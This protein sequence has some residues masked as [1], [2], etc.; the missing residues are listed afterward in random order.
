MK[1]QE[2]CSTEK[3]VFTKDEV[4][5]MFAALLF[6]EDQWHVAE[7]MLPF[8]KQMGIHGESG[9]PDL[10]WD[11]L[12][13]IHCRGIRYPDGSPI[14]YPEEDEGHKLTD[15]ELHDFIEQWHRK[16]EMQSCKES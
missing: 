3:N 4:L 1:N 9:S 16:Q 8:L 10:P 14:F 7:E 5:E 15:E 11:L 12:W 6:C 13:E 2:S